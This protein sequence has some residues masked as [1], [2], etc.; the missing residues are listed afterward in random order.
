MWGS[1]LQTVRSHDLNQ[2]QESDAQPTEPPRHPYFSTILVKNSL[3]PYLNVEL[4]C[5][6]LSAGYHGYKIDSYHKQTLPYFYA[7]TQK[8]LGERQVSFRK[9]GTNEIDIRSRKPKLKEIKISHISTFLHGSLCPQRNRALAVTK[10]RFVLI[11]NYYDRIISFFKIV[12]SV[13]NKITH[14]STTIHSPLCNRYLRISTQRGPWV[15]QSGK[16]PTLAPV[17]ISQCVGLSPTSGSVLTAQTLEA[18]LDSVFPSLSLSLSAPPLLMLSVKNKY[19][20]IKEKDIYPETFQKIMTYLDLCHF[21][22]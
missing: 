16:H 11:T 4:G 5:C 10:T 17:M 14:Y 19:M 7:N 3:Q 1:I 2:N 9:I 13:V 20:N 6:F 18:A 21:R 22:G 12:I 8:D 15:A